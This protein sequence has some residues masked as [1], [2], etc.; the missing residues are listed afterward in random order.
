MPAAP[1]G[2]VTSTTLRPARRPAASVRKPG[3]RRSRDRCR[4]GR[5][6]A[7]AAAPPL[8]PARILNR[9]RELLERDQAK[10]AAVITAEHGKV[11]S[12]AKGEVQ[13]GTRGGRVRHRHSAA[14]QGRVHRRGRH[15][16]R[17][18]FDP[19]AA[20][21]GRR[22]HAVQFPGDGAAV[23]VPGGARVR[24]HIRP[25]AKREGSVGV[26]RAGAAAQGSR[27]ARRCLQRGAT[28]T[29]KPSTRCSTARTMEAISF[30]GST[31]IAEYIYA[32]GTATG[33]RVQALGG[34]KNHMVVLPDADLDQTV[35]ALIG[36]AYGSAGERCM[37]I[38]VAVAVGDQVADALCRAAQEQAGD[39][40]GRARRRA[41]RRDGPARHRRPPANAC[42]ATS[43]SASQEGATLVTDGRPVAARVR[44]VLPRRDAVRSCHAVDADLSGGDLRSGAVGG[45]RARL[46]RRARSS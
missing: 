26:D 34:A 11:L 22:H 33:K 3:R 44:R 27:A 18:L 43:T 24:Q 37:A 7:W 8:Q 31:P 4:R 23:D 1:G 32:R 41:R 38:S 21:R 19:P 42:A 13:R 25:E 12:D 9:F 14:A 15:G 16:R 10:L 2:R 46:R 35:D 36:A 17:Q 5:I 45:A 29:R 30:V 28:A 6:S 39:A 40:A 20:G